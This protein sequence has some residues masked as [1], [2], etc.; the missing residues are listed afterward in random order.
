MC[1]QPVSFAN[2]GKFEIYCHHSSPTLYPEEAHD[3]V[4]VCVPLQH[5][6]YSVTLQSHT[7][8]AIVKDLGARD[9]LVIP[10]RQ[11]HAVT[12][13]RSAGLMCLQLSE[14]FMIEALDVSQLRL[15]DSFTV[16]DPLISAAAAQVHKALNSEGQLGPTF[17]AAIAMT[18]AYRIGVEAP[19][20][21]PIKPAERVRPLPAHQLARVENFVQD[22]LDQPIS[23]ARL[24]GLVGLSKWHFV[25][26]FRASHGLSPHDFIVQRRLARAKEL[27]AK[28]DV[29]ITSVALDVGMSHSHFSRTF[30]SRFGLSPREFR[31]L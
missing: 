29:S 1:G 10:P 30:L 7:G 25:R 3:T 8:R 11:P 18:I 21:G 12:W 15:G 20:G 5:A 4:Q 14:A 22:H 9:I 17:G 28:S 19:A 2:P 6:L 27:L 23:L 26:R 24:A 16:R 13:R 31:Q